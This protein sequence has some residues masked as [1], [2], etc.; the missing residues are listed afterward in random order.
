MRKN[1]LPMTL[2]LFAEPDGGSA[3]AGEN[4]GQQT[5]GN[6]GK[7]NAPAFDYEKIASI[8]AGKQSVTEDTVLKSYFKRQGMSKEEMDDAINAFK[9]KR[10]ANEPDPNALQEQITQAQ[11]A[12]TQ[13]VIEKDGLLL[14]IEMGLDA[15]TVPY[16]LKM[17]DTT[18]VV[19]EDGMID[20][21]K[22]KEAINK[23]ITDIPALKPGSDT[24][25]GFMQVGSG[26]DG[27]QAGSDQGS[28]IAGIFGNSK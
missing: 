8:I 2:Q 13:A 17:A 16:I 23:V 7:E 12:A 6:A 1:F 19:K 14:G 27:G 4:S 18:A 5:A 25:H 11:K 22:L 26:G 28:I 9:E 20:Q 10:K 21:D 24:G 15:K 3:G